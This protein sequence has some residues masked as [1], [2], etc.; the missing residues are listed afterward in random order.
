MISYHKGN[1]L[2][3]KAEA[4]V[5]T[6]NCVG[7]MGKGIALQFK[8]AFPSVYGQYKSACDKGQIRIGQIQIVATGSVFFPRYII[9]FPTKNHWKGNSKIEDVAAGLVDLR[10]QLIE[11]KISSVAV[12]PL[13]CGNGGLDWLQV[14]KLIEEALSGLEN[15]DIQVYEPVGAPAPNT[16][17]VNTKKPTLT[18]ARAAVLRLLHA[19]SQLDFDIDVNQLVVQKLC[20]FLQ[21][22]GE[23]LKL[24]YERAYYG[25]YADNLKF[26][27][28]SMEGHYTRGYGDRS[29]PTGI[30]QLLP[31]DLAELNE[32][33]REAPET[34][35]RLMRV[36]ELVDT[37]HTPYLLELLSTVLYVAN[38]DKNARLS[39]SYVV[40]AVKQWNDRK[41]FLF[42]GADVKMA[43]EHLRNLGWISIEAPNNEYGKR[44]DRIDWTS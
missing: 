39:Y 3:A 29:K 43:W 11:K 7:V 17:P 12:P 32:T 25:P 2:N 35:D 13:G 22:A 30:I 31:V 10:Q 18:M 26:V 4:L 20:Y 6:V 9:N 28:Q 14:K 44:F 42:G 15:I 23:P 27:L 1:L 38:E 19:Y 8:Q 16:M 33:L 21:V 36:L 34:V 5:N 37:F 40:T 41:E 24:N